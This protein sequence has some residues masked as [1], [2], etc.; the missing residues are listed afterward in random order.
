MA[1]PVGSDLP[2]RCSLQARDQANTCRCDQPRGP[3]ARAQRH[4]SARIRK[5][6]ADFGQP[7]PAMGL[8]PRI[9]QFAEHLGTC[10]GHGTAS[11]ARIRAAQPARCCELSD[12]AVKPSLEQRGEGLLP[13]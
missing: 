5:P 1:W 13:V 10:A 7:T 3:L 9:P 11:S 4:R 6:S 8:R 12:A 2:A